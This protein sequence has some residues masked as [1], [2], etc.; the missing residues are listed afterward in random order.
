MVMRVNE[1]FSAQSLADSNKISIINVI[2]ISFYDYYDN[3]T[4]GTL[5]FPDDQ[6]PRGDLD[7]YVRSL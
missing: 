5:L 4:E 2:N 7:F 1:I 3:N 6:S